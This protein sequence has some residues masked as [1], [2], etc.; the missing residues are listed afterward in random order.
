MLTD[1]RYALAALALI[2][3]SPT[4]RAATAQCL[5]Q[6]EGKTYVEGRCP[7]FLMGS[8]TMVG[9]DGE[10]RFSPYFASISENPDGSAEG[11]WSSVPRS[12]HAQTD[13]GSLK[14]DGHCWVN[15]T[16]KICAK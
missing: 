5:I 8:T 15:A 6:V 7:V 9:S 4:A 16:A 10:G 11:R 2:T 12:T 1:M 13:L 14:R 3:L